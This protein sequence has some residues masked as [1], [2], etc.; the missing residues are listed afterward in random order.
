MITWKRTWS[1][2]FKGINTTVPRSVYAD[3]LFAFA[4]FLL[5]FFFFFESSTNEYWLVVNAS[6]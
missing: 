4:C 2:N 3:I 1:Q 6:F 5:V